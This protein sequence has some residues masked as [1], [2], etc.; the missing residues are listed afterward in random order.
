MA[1]GSCEQQAGGFGQSD[2]CAVCLLT[3]K[4]A[5]PVARVPAETTAEHL[6]RQAADVADV[7]GRCSA[8]CVMKLMMA[9]LKKS[10]SEVGGCFLL[11][12]WPENR[13]MQL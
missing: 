10:G 1:D 6:E 9:D 3:K 7:S 8:G 13:L 11:P 12:E 2:Q 5:K 4:E